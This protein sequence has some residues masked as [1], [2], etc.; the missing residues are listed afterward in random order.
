[1]ASSGEH[2]GYRAFDWSARAADN[3]NLFGYLLTGINIDQY[4][5]G[6][7][8][9]QSVSTP[10]EFMAAG[11]ITRG[12]GVASRAIC[13][14]AVERVF[15]ENTPASTPIGRSGYPLRVSRG[16]NTPGSIGNLNYSGHAFDEMQ[17]DGIMPSVVRHTVDTAAPISGKIPG[18]TVYLD[19]TN[20]IGSY[21]Y[22]DG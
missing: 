11:D 8:P 2:S 4:T 9:I 10:F 15:A 18:T 13:P 19:G 1:M 20:N 17:S 3:I 7:G 21:R 22:R 14:T 12:I 6:D 5:P 16:T